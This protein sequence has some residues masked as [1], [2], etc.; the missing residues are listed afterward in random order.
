[1]TKEELQEMFDAN[2]LS[3]EAL[4]VIEDVLDDNE[5]LDDDEEI[6]DEEIIDQI[7]YTCVGTYNAC[8]YLAKQLGGDMSDAIAEGLTDA[9]AMEKYYIQQEILG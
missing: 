1:M 3:E 8:N 2:E 5:E 4:S 9:E 7:D 6:E